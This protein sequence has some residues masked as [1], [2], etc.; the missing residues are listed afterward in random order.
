MI[1]DS[2]IIIYSNLAG[3]ESLLNWLKKPE[4]GLSVSAIS[5]VE[6]LGYPKLPAQ[7]KADLETLFA[8]LH[9][10]TITNTVIEL[11][12]QLRQQRKRSLGDSINRRYRAGTQP[13]RRH[14]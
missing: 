12:V 11:A 7:D 4:V 2:N 9:I 6:V 5:V 1:L 14:Q 8:R 13:T 10:V 3:Y